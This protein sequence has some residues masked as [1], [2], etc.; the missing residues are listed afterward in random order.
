VTV[1]DTRD[2]TGGFTGPL[3]A[4]GVLSLPVAGVD[5]VPATGVTAVVLNVTVVD[6]TAGSYLSVYPDGATYAG[7]PPSNLNFS[8]GEII[9]NLV[10][11]PVGAD[12]NVDFFND[13]GSTQVLATLEGFYTS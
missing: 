11:V 5:G 13:L 12:G 1:L 7:D 3:G 2:G 10:V 8:P 9:P 4:G 6:T